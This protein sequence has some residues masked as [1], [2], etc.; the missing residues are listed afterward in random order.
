[1]TTAE[2]QV[3]DVYLYARVYASHFGT[4]QMFRIESRGEILSSWR[5]NEARAWEN[6]L[7]RMNNKKQM[8]NKAAS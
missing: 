5:E 3:V 8:D 7:K 6:A 2:A 1:M 4:K